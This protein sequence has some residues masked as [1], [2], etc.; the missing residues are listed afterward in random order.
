VPNGG[1]LQ[2]SLA[3]PADRQALVWMMQG[4]ERVLTVCLGVLVLKVPCSAMPAYTYKQQRQ[5]QLP[6]QQS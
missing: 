2:H 5:K 6:Q 3:A 1:D 4:T